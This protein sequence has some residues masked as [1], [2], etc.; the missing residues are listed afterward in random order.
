MGRTSD[1]RERLLQSGMELIHAGGYAQA[2]I[3]EIC[4]HAG[5]RKGSFYHFFPSKGE[6]A[7]AVVE[8][9]RERSDAI[10]DQALAPDLPPGERIVRLFALAGEIQ[11]GFKAEDGWVKGCPFA[12]L[13]LEMSTRD[14][15]LRLLLE[16]VLQGVIQRLEG[17]VREAGH[18]PA[19]AQPTAEAI[20]SLFEGA[21][22][23]AKTRND[24]EVIRRMGVVTR[25]LLEEA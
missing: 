4:D 25:A 13:A 12:N 14:E 16:Q 20:F 18:P 8:R 10:L 19:T 24:P 1:A 23:L 21:I 7:L 9:F 6:L 3:Q 5:V 15:P 11:Q 22:L 17:V 2:G